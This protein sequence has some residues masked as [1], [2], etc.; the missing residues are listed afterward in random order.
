MEEMK[1]EAWDARERQT[2][3]VETIARSKN[4]GRLRSLPLKASLSVMRGRRVLP[5]YECKEWL[6]GQD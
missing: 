4:P 6:Q 1:L 3:S 5:Q 2:G